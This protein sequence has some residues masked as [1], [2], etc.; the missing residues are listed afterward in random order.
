[1][2]TFKLFADM[3]GMLWKN[4][5][6]APFIMYEGIR[7]KDL[8]NAKQS[9]EKVLKSI[10]VGFDRCPPD[11]CGSSEA[12]RHTK[13]ELRRN[14]STLEPQKTSGKPRNIPILYFIFERSF[15]SV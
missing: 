9:E 12:S 8:E 10:Y 13:G 3:I 2:E 15:S 1:M 14:G 11:S 5:V 6:D 7:R 4:K